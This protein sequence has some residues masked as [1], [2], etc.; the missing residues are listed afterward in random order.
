MQQ[1]QN[2]KFLINNHKTF[3]WFLVICMLAWLVGLMPLIQ[4][5]PA[6]IFSY[7]NGHHSKKADTFFAA[8]TYIGTAWVI[9][10]VSLLLLLYPPYRNKSFFLLMTLCNIVPLLLTHLIKN[11][12]Q[13][14]R[15]LHIFQ[16]EEW[17]H[18]PEGQPL[19][20]A[21]SFPS[22]HTEAAFALCCFIALI[23]PNKYKWCG[24]ILFA[25]AALTAY[26]RIYLVQHFYADVFAGSIIGV[27]FCFLT[28]YI[29]NRF[30]YN[31]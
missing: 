26:S 14:P 11:I 19:Q 29:F 31:K 5:T 16:S 18:F 21:N 24:V 20:Y 27:V 15:P 9:V 12:L 17:L 4:Y 10:P 25:L 8:V 30:R 1:I 22:G 13:R 7:I 6:E 2:H 3:L 23:L 28:F